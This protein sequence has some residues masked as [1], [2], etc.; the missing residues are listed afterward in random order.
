MKC[1]DHH[2]IGK[3]RIDRELFYNHPEVVA[4][5]QK[6][7]LIV[8]AVWEDFGDEILYIGFSDYFAP[9]PKGNLAPQY[10]LDI[11]HTPK[12]IRWTWEHWF[13]DKAASPQ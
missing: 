3:Y 2:Q 9:Q 6:G 5:I 1:V 7:V 8:S 11:E 4:E 13:Y 12:G 10:D